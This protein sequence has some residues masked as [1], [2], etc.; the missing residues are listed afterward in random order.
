MYIVYTAAHLKS[1]FRHTRRT[2]QLFLVSV[3]PQN[4]GKHVLVVF[5]KVLVPFRTV[6]LFKTP[7]TKESIGVKG[8]DF[9][10]YQE[11]TSAHIEH[12]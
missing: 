12:L 7:G 10:L 3:K 5:Y 9:R 8:E 1:I 6:K 11:V 2:H 4:G